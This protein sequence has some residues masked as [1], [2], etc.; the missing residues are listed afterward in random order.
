MEGGWDIRGVPP[1]VHS[2]FFFCFW[3]FAVFLRFL[4]VRIRVHASWPWSSSTES[5]LCSEPCSSLA[6]GLLCSLAPRF[7]VKHLLEHTNVCL[8][9]LLLHSRAYVRGCSEIR[10]FSTFATTMRIYCVH[11]FLVCCFYCP[12]S[13]VFFVFSAA[14]FFRCFEAIWYAL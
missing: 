13:I 14:A 5:L 10:F 12:M 11:T 2:R 9:Q 1:G 4:F 7:R 6:F 3:F 8:E